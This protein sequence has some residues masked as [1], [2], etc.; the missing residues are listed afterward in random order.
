MRGVNRESS[1]VNNHEIYKT[2]I[3]KHQSM[4]KNYF[5]ISFRNLLKRKGLTAFNILGL[6]IGIT[7]CLLLFQYVSYE[8]SYDDYSAAQ[9]LYRMR[10]DS[11]QDGKLAWQSATSYPITGPY[12][13][14]DLPEVQNF[15]RLKDYELLLSNDP[16]RVKFF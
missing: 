14:R 4:L 12:M 7:C 1:I 9:P 5:A 2:D 15:C 8:N 13:K 16:R 10:L 3:A 11:Y 6:T